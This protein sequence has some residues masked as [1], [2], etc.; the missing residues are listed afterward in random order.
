MEAVK[1]AN[2]SRDER[3]FPCGTPRVN[4]PFSFGVLIVVVAIES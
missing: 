2:P 1:A 3:P 4:R